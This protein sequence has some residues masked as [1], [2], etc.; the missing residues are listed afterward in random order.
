LG[1]TAPRVVDGLLDRKLTE[2]AGLLNNAASPC[3][4]A[5]VFVQLC[6]VCSVNFFAFQLAKASA[7]SPC[8]RFAPKR[9]PAGPSV[10]GLRLR[11]AAFPC[12]GHSRLA[13]ANRDRKIRSK[14]RMRS[15]A[16]GVGD[17]VDATGC[18]A[19]PNSG[20]SGPISGV[21]GPNLGDL[22]QQNSDLAGARSRR[23]L[24][25]PR[26]QNLGPVRR[27]EPSRAA[28]AEPGNCLG[29]LVVAVEL[30]RPSLWRSNRRLSRSEARPAIH[31]RELP[32]V[33]C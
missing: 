11:R 31:G 24:P 19:S 6:P 5:R 21:S 9:G 10:P 8:I 15:P 16:A 1:E 7:K 32:R 12:C 25:R 33:A 20:V 4:V 28:I 22:G 3:S 13:R 30:S 17:A 29:S 26:T 18:P 27:C 14:R 2:P 23:V